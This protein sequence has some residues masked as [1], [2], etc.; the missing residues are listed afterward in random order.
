MIDKKLWNKY[1]P[2][3]LISYDNYVRVSNQ[4]DATIFFY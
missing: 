3:N 1:L 4:Q 2:L